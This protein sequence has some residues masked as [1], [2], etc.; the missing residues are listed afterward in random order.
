ME[1]VYR[2][3]IFKHQLLWG[4]CIPFTT[5]FVY[6]RIVDGPFNIYI[7]CFAFTLAGLFFIGAIGLNY[8]ILDPDRIT[9]RSSIY[10]FW[11]K[12]FLYKDIV[13]IMFKGDAAYDTVYLHI[14]TR[15][16]KS[17]RYSVCCVKKSDLEKIATDLK[18]S[19]VALEV[20]LSIKRDYFH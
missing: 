2:R 14:M 7:K 10:F 12:T 17:H 8:V 19:N 3:S 5:L 15:N 20:D 4:Y 6:A 9:F 11:H 18:E 16:N 13:K 1:K